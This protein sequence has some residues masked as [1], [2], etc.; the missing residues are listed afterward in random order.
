VNVP[1]MVVSNLG[2]S[3]DDIADAV[4]D[5]AGRATHAFGDEYL[6]QELSLVPQCVR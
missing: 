6:L 3:Q 2:V 1:G 4:G 5:I